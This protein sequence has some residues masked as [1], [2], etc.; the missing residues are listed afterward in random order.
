MAADWDRRMLGLAR[1]ISRWSKDPSTKVGAVIMRSDHA[2][3]AT[4]FNGFSPGHPDLPE[5]YAD[6]TYKYAHVRHAEANALG[7]I[8]FRALGCTMFTSFPSCPGCLRLCAQSG[9]IR[10]VQPTLPTQGKTKK[11]IKEWTDRIDR[12]KEYAASVRLDLEYLDGF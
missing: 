6:R 8:S 1:H 10:V 7:F 2:V 5:Q 4:G 3:L 9:I 11:W 12:S